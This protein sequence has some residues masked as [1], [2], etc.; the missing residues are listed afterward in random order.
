MAPW[1]LGVLAFICVWSQHSES[2]IGGESSRPACLHSKTPLLPNK[3][4][5]K[6]TYTVIPNKTIPWFLLK[7]NFPTGAFSLTS[8]AF[9]FVGESHRMRKVQNCDSQVT[10]F[11]KSVIRTSFLRQLISLTP[12]TYGGKTGSSW[13]HKCE[14]SSGIAMLTGFCISASHIQVHA[15]DSWMRFAVPVTGLLRTFLDCLA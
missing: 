4:R 7:L 2:R 11:L 6:G 3:R 10:S 14:G 5:G 12:F 15:P 8:T 1:N 13:T 9:P